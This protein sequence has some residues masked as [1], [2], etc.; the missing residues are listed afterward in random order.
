MVIEWLKFKVT[1]EVREKFIQQDE[2]IWTAT[3]A[4][5]PGFLGKE[6][7]IKPNTSDE[8]VIVIRW[9]TRENWKAVPIDVLSETDKKFS[10]AMGKNTYQ[11]IETGEYQ[12][13]KFPAS[14]S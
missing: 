7:W 5:F 4:K 2:E 3:L 1:P 12:I 14:R 13:R 9:Q 8:L 11:M 10:Q 6:I